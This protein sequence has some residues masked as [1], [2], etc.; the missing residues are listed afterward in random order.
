MAWNED[1]DNIYELKGLLVSTLTQ[2]KPTDTQC[3]P[4]VR[5]TSSLGLLPRLSED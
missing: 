1:T 4:D 5:F 3:V 2:Q